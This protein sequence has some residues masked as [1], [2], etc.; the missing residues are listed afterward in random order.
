MTLTPLADNLT[1]LPRLSSHTR[2]IL[3]AKPSAL[4]L[5]ARG[6][7]F[8]FTRQLKLK[9]TSASF[10]ALNKISIGYLSKSHKKLHKNFDIRLQ[11]WQ[12]IVLAYE[13]PKA[14][15]YRFRYNQRLIEA[16]LVVSITILSTHRSYI[17]IQEKKIND[18]STNNPK[19]A[20]L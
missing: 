17:Q 2:S 10:S 7:V 20:K 15:V 1:L 14:Y 4:T 13:E 19:N 6:D 3:I 16:K 11:A 9:F 12:R 8:F 5:T 18:W